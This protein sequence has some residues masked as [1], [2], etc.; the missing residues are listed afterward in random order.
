L[1]RAGCAPINGVQIKAV[2]LLLNTEEYS[3]QI[4]SES[5]V[6]SIQAMALKIDSEAAVFRA[7]HPSTPAWKAMGII[8]FKNRRAARAVG[9]G[10]EPASLN[11]KA[12]NKTG[13]SIPK[14]PGPNRSP[15]PVPPTPEEDRPR[16]LLQPERKG[17]TVAA[18]AKKD[19]RGEIGRWQPGTHL[20]RCG[21]CGSPFVGGRKAEHCADC[22]Y[23]AEEVAHAS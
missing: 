8:W 5:L 6:M 21:P 18:S 22:A 23:R 9:T 19:S 14:P 3:T 15:K 20:R 12:P 2:D 16:V 17:E 4:T 11:S 13:E 7:A 10:S 1:A